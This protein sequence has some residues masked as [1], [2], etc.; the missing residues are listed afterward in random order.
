MAVLAIRTIIQ[1]PTVPCTQRTHISSLGSL[2]VQENGMPSALMT[3]I[4]ANQW[5]QTTVELRLGYPW[6]RASRTWRGLADYAV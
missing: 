5:P 2:Q 1:A 6:S 4:N 3:L